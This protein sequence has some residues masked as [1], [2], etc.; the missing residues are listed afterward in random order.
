MLPATVPNVRQ[1]VRDSFTQGRKTRNSSGRQSSSTSRMS[2]YSMSTSVM[3]SELPTPLRQHSSSRNDHRIVENNKPR[4]TR[5][6][7][8]T[9][10]STQQSMNSKK[11]SP[12]LKNGTSRVKCTVDPERIK[13]ILKERSISNYQKDFA[14]PKPFSVRYENDTRRLQSF[15]FHELGLQ[16]A[17]DKVR[18]RSSLYHREPTIPTLGRKGLLSKAATTA[19]NSRDSYNKVHSDITRPLMIDIHKHKH[20]SDVSRAFKWTNRASIKEPWTTYI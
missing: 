11:I 8:H 17:A 19:A 6:S 2:D 4:S 18:L 1:R 3:S 12:A 9:S 5:Q 13:Q 15:T 14:T 20:P 16:Q 7:N 10:L